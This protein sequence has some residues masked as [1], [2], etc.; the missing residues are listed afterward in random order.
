MLVVAWRVVVS[1]SYG[2]TGE[3]YMCVS[4]DVLQLVAPRAGVAVRGLAHPGCTNRNP[5]FFFAS[6]VASQVTSECNTASR[7]P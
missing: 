7:L 5:C 4:N 1:S 3:A 2:S 6:R